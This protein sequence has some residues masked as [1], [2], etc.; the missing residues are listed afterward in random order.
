MKD[1]KNYRPKVSYKGT[2]KNPRDTL[3]NM[4]LWATY[5]PNLNFEENARLHHMFSVFIQQRNQ[6]NYRKE[7]WTLTFD[8]FKEAWDDKWDNRGR[9]KGTYC[10]TRIDQTKPWTADNYVVMVRGEV[11]ADWFRRFVTPKGIFKDISEA[12][13]A[14]NLSVP[15]LRKI[16]DANPDEF[17]YTKK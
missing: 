3:D 14:Y 8:E 4:K 16:K 6:A 5:D 2:P 10:S 11:Y 15:E 13:D 1:Y 9:K 17:Y 12:A 7:G